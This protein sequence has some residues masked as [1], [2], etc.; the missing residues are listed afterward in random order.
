MFAVRML[1]NAINA[2]EVDPS[3]FFKNP[4][5]FPNDGIFNWGLERHRDGAN[6]TGLF[7]L[8]DEAGF[9]NNGII[10]SHTV[11]LWTEEN[12]HAIIVGRHEH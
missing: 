9:S 10:N 11:H 6:F 8:A 1:K 2:I 5:T 12:I 7:L 4:W 3:I